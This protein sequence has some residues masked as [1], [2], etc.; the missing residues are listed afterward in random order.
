METTQLRGDTQRT[1][2]SWAIFILGLLVGLFG[3]GIRLW[4]LGR[5]SINADQAVVGLMAEQILHGHFSAFYWGQ[6][7]GGGEPYFVA[8]IFAVFGQST[9]SLGMAPVLLD[10]VAALLLW[11]IGNKLFGP[12]IGIAAALLFWI[13]PEVYIWQSTIEYGFRW[14]VLDVGLGALLLTL[15]VIGG[16]THRRT[17]I[18]AIGLLLGAG[19]WGSPEIMYFVLPIAAYLIYAIVRFSFRLRLVEV[20]VGVLGAFIGAGAWIESNV[21]THF[22]SLHSGVQPDPSFLYHLKIFVQH[23]LPLLLGL[24]LRMTGQ[25]LIG[26]ILGYLATGLAIAIGLAVLVILAR[27]GEAILLV[28]FCL[29]APFIYALSPF[30]WYWSDGRYGVFLAPAT[31]LVVVVGMREI[32]R[33]N[34]PGTVG[35]LAATIRARGD[36]WNG[37]FAVAV[38]LGLS[39]A[40]MSMI[41]PYKPNGVVTTG[42]KSWTSWVS[43]PSS[44]FATIAAELHHDGITDVYAGYW[45]AYPLMFASKGTLISSDISYVRNPTF[46]SQVEHDAAPAWLFLNPSDYRLGVALTGVS[47]MDP[48]C[49]AGTDRCLT[50]RELKVYLTRHKIGYRTYAANPFV[51]IIPDKPVS[52]VALTRTYHLRA[53]YPLSG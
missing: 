25:W 29:F 39:L 48:S 37:A 23:G 41:A 40:A 9:Y 38:G 46:L 3:L 35:R 15:R 11:R 30:T 27:R 44:G 47:L 14:F 31:S 53:A 28:C 19:W 1:K 50:P 10:L 26:P 49:A 24:Q 2:I 22:A 4:A 12:Q 20:V 21:R 51:A 52:P 33:L 5:H 16:A 7:Y 45:V 8:L 18:G 17:E 36:L 6:S 43:D 13:W 42:S 32:V 34:L